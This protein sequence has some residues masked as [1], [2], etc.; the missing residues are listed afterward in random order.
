MSTIGVITS[1]EKVLAFPG[2]KTREREE[3]VTEFNDS[4]LQ[5]RCWSRSYD[6]RSRGGPCR[7]FPMPDAIA[8]NLILAMSGALALDRILSMSGTVAISASNRYRN[9]QRNHAGND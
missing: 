6:D 2:V 8:F 1:P 9:K 5:H 3:Q 4:F 7:V